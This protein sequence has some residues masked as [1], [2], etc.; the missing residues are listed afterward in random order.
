MCFLL[1][2]L[3][4]LPYVYSLYTSRLEPGIDIMYM[5]GLGRMV[6]N[7]L[8]FLPMRACRSKVDLETFIFQMARAQ[9][10]QIVSKNGYLLAWRPSARLKHLLARYNALYAKENSV[11]LETEENTSIGEASFY[12]Q[13]IQEKRKYPLV[14]SFHLP[15]PNKTN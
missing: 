6:R 12:E 1:A 8:K 4:F 5:G 10:K 13:Y 9:N 15:A 3:V 7:A 14:P 11:F 2:Q